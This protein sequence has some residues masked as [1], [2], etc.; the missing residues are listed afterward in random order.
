VLEGEELDSPPSEKTMIE[1]PFCA[2]CFLSTL[3][4]KVSSNGFFGTDMRN[5]FLEGISI[6]KNT[7]A[8]GAF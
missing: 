5:S 1:L 6:F 2:A 7:F 4:L 8:T 3:Y